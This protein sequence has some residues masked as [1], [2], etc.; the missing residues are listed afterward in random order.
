M[1]LSTKPYANASGLPTPN[2]SRASTQAHWNV[3]I[4]PGALGKAV[5]NPMK[6][7]T[8][9]AALNGTAKPKAQMIT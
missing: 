9:S 7:K 1:A 3:P 4:M 2:N 5:P 6:M 8:M